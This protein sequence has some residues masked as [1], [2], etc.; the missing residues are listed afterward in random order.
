MQLCYVFTDSIFNNGDWNIF[1]QLTD[2]SH[3]QEIHCSLHVTLLQ[4][5][6]A[7]RKW[8][9]NVVRYILNWTANTKMKI[10]QEMKF[11]QCFS[12]DWNLLVY[13]TVWT[14]KRYI[15][16]HYLQFQSSPKR[17]NLVK[18]TVALYQGKACYAPNI[19]TKQEKWCVV[20]RTYWEENRS[21][22]TQIHLTHIRKNSLRPSALALTR[23]IN[24]ELCILERRDFPFFLAVRRHCYDILK[25]KSCSPFPV[26]GWSPNWS[27]SLMDWSLYWDLL[28]IHHLLFVGYYRNHTF[29]SHTFILHTILKFKSIHFSNKLT[30]WTCIN[31]KCTIAWLQVS[32]LN[33]DR[34]LKHI[35]KL[36]LNTNFDY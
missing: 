28:E 32:C 19:M 23:T 3:I 18:E 31:N 20:G 22:G 35:M 24:Q 1:L 16:S 36:L 4:L 17:L 33:N 10:M 34:Q 25:T 27:A 12:V 15:R 9:S 11:S 29:F 7:D 26:L 8:P 5:K 21:E 13:N 2:P 6:Q 30:I 14:G